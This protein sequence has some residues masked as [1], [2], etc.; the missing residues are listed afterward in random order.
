MGYTYHYTTPI[1]VMDEL[2]TEANALIFVSATTRMTAEKSLTFPLICLRPIGLC[3]KTQTRFNRS[4]R[5]KA[6]LTY[7]L[8]HTSLQLCQ[9]SSGL[10]RYIHY[11]SF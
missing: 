2:V 1:G 8:I 5:L 3:A 11:G 6:N 10:A 9:F 7:F 4:D